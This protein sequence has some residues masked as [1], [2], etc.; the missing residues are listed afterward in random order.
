MAGRE[1][2]N[3]LEGFYREWTTFLLW[4][5]PFR[6]LPPVNTRSTI[7]PGKINPAFPAHPCCLA[8][9]CG[10]E[11]SCKPR[12]VRAGGWSG[13]YLQ[14]GVSSSKGMYL[15]ALHKHGICRRRRV[16]VLMSKSKAQLESV[17]ISTY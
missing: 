9:S 4:E 14:A 3:P 2:K 8:A 10:T 11:R 6:K 16:L 1:V 7:G 5:Q 15:V 17:Q 13:L 12:G